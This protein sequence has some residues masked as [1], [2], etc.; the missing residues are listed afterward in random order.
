MAVLALC[1]HGWL[2]LLASTKFTAVSWLWGNRDWTWSYFKYSHQNGWG[3]QFQ[4]EFT[5]A[6]VLAYI[7]AFGTGLLGYALAGRRVHGWV[8][9][10]AVAL[11]A[12]GLVSFLIEGSH[13][14][15]NHNL[16]WIATCS[17]ASLLLAGI[18]VAQLWAGRRSGYAAVMTT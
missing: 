15:R 10:P 2:L 18:S 6:V 11:C 3:Y 8:S 4:S 16:S 7:G 1:I 9:V 12:V 14:L 5:L 13:W 17:A